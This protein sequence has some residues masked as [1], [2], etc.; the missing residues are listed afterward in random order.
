MLSQV[1][2]VKYVGGLLSTGLLAGTQFGYVY[3]ATTG[4]WQTVERA[5]ITGAKLVA[6]AYLM[7]VA[8]TVSSGW[9]WAG[10]AA[11]DAVAGGVGSVI[12]GG[13]FRDGFLSA[14]FGSLAGNVGELRYSL[15]GRMLVGGLASRVGGGDFASGAIMSGIQ[16]YLNDCSHGDHCLNPNDYHDGYVDTRVGE[17]EWAWVP[18][19]YAASAWYAGQNGGHI[20][21]YYEDPEALHDALRTAAA[22][23]M[24]ICPEC[25]LSVTLDAAS[26]V[27][28][29]SH[30]HFVSV[31]SGRA[32][33]AAAFAR[34]FSHA[35]SERMGAAMDWAVG[36]EE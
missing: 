16:Y 8:G 13:D 20:D 29:L 14:G 2:E 36:N 17:S 33:S 27:D 21:I 9:G 32:T 35:A 15:M 6:A 19:E 34:G 31:I 1:S 4:D 7:Q 30:G 23:S 3:G 24:V 11:A 28:D 22:A 10:H 25:A 18:Q 5:H 12:Q 26:T